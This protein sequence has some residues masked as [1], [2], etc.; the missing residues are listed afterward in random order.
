MSA[1]VIPN[2]RHVLAGGGALGPE[3]IGGQCE[4]PSRFRNQKR[5]H[6]RRGMSDCGAALLHGLAAGRV[7]LVCRACGIRRDQHKR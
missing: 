5:A 2:R 4:L 6:L 1:S 7:A 3:R